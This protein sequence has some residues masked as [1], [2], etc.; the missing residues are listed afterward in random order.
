MD[1]VMENDFFVPTNKSFCGYY[2]FPSSSI[3][4]LQCLLQLYQHA[5]N[6]ASNAYLGYSRVDAQTMLQRVTN[7]LVT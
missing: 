3:S 6:T 2:S 5:A 7:M 1:F 4:H